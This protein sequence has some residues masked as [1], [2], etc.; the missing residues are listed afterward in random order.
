MKLIK[1]CSIK[2]IGEALQIDKVACQFVKRFASCETREEYNELE[3][4]YDKFELD[5]N[6]YFNLLSTLLSAF[7]KIIE[8]F[9][10]EYIGK[11]E[12]CY[13]WTPKAEYVNTGDTYNST[14]ILK[15]SNERFYL[16]CWADIVE[17]A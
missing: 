5:T 3:S 7:D 11:Q 16:G 12:D 1:Y 17:G 15:H 4:E 8:G 10:V 9:G 13:N 2:E 14:I 6:Q